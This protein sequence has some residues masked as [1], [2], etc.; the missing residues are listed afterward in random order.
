MSSSPSTRWPQLSLFRS[1]RILPARRWC[2]L[3][4]VGWLAVDARHTFLPLGASEE[5]LP[6]PAPAGF[7]QAAG[8]MN[9]IHGRPEVAFERGRSSPPAVRLPAPVQLEL[10]AQQRLTATVLRLENDRI[11]LLLPWGQRCRCPVSTIRGWSQP[12]GSLRQTLSFDLQQRGPWPR[13]PA[14]ASTAVT[15]GG[16][17]LRLI[18]GEQFIVPAGRIAGDASAVATSRWVC[19]LSGQVPGTLEWWFADSTERPA[20]STSGSP[21]TSEAVPPSGADAQPDHNQLMPRVQRLRLGHAPTDGSESVVQSS[22]LSPSSQ[23]PDRQLNWT[24]LVEW[25]T[26]GRIAWVARDGDPLQR[27]VVPSPANATLVLRWVPDSNRSESQRDAATAAD[28]DL[29][30]IKSQ[31]AA[32]RFVLETTVLRLPS[33]LPSDDLDTLTRQS[34]DT[35]LGRLQFWDRDQFRLLMAGRV[36]TGKSASVRAVSLRTR[37]DEPSSSGTLNGGLVTLDLTPWRVVGSLLPDRIRGRLVACE[38]MSSADRGTSSHARHEPQ[39]VVDHPLLGRL[40]IPSQF[41]RRWTWSGWGSTEL[42]TTQPLHLGDGFRGDF[43]HGAADRSGLTVTALPTMDGRGQREVWLWQTELEPSGPGAP[44]A[45][46]FLTE[47]RHGRL[48]T[49]LLWNQRPLA[50]LNERLDWKTPATSE[51]QL[52]RVTLPSV[53]ATTRLNL[54]QLQLQLESA[55]GPLDNW[56]L[57]QLSIE[58]TNWPPL[59]PAAWPSLLRDWGLQ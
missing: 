13:V 41:V 32:S 4:I 1:L 38:S 21:R 11:T 53:E 19:E 3:L 7:P 34:G 36:V 44:P 31:L 12:A 14:D 37:P 6:G 28:S 17:D 48:T 49:R 35:L 56:E 42:L 51:P 23:T 39:F 18:A 5:R 55:G 46:P 9:P 25:W 20:D 54:L 40:W 24:H 59:S 45:S 2:W 43:R 15:I 29:S 33:D 22:R 26:I 10:G 50:V 27:S 8:S 58:Q 47:L 16:N 30:V 57:D 52:L